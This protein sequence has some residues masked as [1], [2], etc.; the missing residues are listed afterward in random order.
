MTSECAAW[1]GSRSSNWNRVIDMF[2]CTVAVSCKGV[3]VE[4]DDSI[5]GYYYS[6]RHGYIW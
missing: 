6:K 1:I 2:R 4:M 5:K 3:F